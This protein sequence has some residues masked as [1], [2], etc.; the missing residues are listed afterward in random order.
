MLSRIN[1]VGC[2]GIRI[3]AVS[4]RRIE[5]KDRVI[6]LPRCPGEP[7]FAAVGRTIMPHHIAVT[8]V[9]ITEVAKYP[10]DSE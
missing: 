5:S 3:A 9:R 7:N 6:S 10:S 2:V 4:V 8:A 1:R